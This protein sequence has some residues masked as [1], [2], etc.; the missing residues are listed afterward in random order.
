MDVLPICM[1]E[2]M[3]C[4]NVCL[5]PCVRYAQRGQKS[6]RNSGTGVIGGR[7]VPCG[8]WELNRNV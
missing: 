8:C 6:I 2:Q 4:L 5:T 1:S 3:F 7:K